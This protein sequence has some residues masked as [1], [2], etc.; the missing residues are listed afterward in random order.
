[1]VM[2]AV[3]LDEKAISMFPNPDQLPSR[4]TR[5]LSLTHTNVFSLSLMFQRPW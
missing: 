1:M 3:V 5:T 2:Q 4:L